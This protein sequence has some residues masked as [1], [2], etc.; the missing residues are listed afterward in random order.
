MVKNLMMSFSWTNALC[1]WR[2]RHRR[3]TYHK[4][5]EKS[6]YKARQKY[7]AKINIWGGISKR[8]TTTIALFGGTS[9]TTMYRKVL[10]ASLFP[11]IDQVYSD[12]F[13]LMQD[14]D[15]KHTSRYIKTY[16][17]MK[18]LNWWKAPA[19]SPDLNPIENVWGSMKQ[20]L[21][22][23]YKPQNLMELKAGIRVFQFG[24]HLHQMFYKIY[25]SHSH[26]YSRYY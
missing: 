2:A 9:T 12:S 4:E 22:I 8:G 6:R 11:F 13:R 10:D 1:N 25:K 21:H 26:S 24:S 20:F 14:N 23:E 15:P 16:F 18:K 7:P 3:V 5:G 19:S 17:E